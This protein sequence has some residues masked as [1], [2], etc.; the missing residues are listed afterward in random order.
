MKIQ[1]KL[2]SFHWK[3]LLQES[4]THW[5]F[6]THSFENLFKQT[7]INHFRSHAQMNF[8]FE[9]KK[10]NSTVKKQQVLDCMWVY[11]YKFMKKKMLMK[12]KTH[13]IMWNNQ[14]VKSNFVSIYIIILIVYFFHVFMMLVLQ[15]QHCHDF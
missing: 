13:L 10:K 2:K 1:Q 12:C 11:V 7:E 3:Q 14:Q 5:N 6:K 8:W 9:I 4:K 15:I